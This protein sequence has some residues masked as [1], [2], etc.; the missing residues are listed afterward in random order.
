MQD[1]SAGAIPS[2]VQS[3]KDATKGI[4]HGFHGWETKMRNLEGKEQEFAYP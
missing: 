3:G 2:S 4:D 1:G